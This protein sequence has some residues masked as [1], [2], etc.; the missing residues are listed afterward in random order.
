M[1]GDHLSYRRATGVAFLGLLLQVIVGLTLLIYGILGRDHAAFTGA[2]FVLVGG[3]IWLALGVVFDQHRRERIEA[4]EEESLAAAALRQSSVFD[5]ASGDLR[6]AARRLAWMHR[7]LMPAVSVLVASSF[8]ALGLL[9]F[10]SAKGSLNPD[11][12]VAPPQR[13]WAIAIGLCAAI[14]GFIFARFVSGMAKQPVWAN[15]RG[16]AAAAVGSALVG[17]VLAVAHFADLAG[18]PAMLRYVPAALCVFSVAMGAEVVLNL[19][20]NLYRPRKA[21]EVP[22]PAFDS[23]FLSFAAAPDKIAESVSGA[24]NYQFGFDV[25]SSWFYR[26]LSRSVLVLVLIG[27]GVVWLMT[28]VE[29]IEPNE[30]GLLL[31]SGRL[32]RQLEPGA[33]L[34]APWPI[35]WVDSANTTSVKRV[36]LATL[37]PG[38][39]GQPILWKTDHGVDEVYAIVQPSLSEA[40]GGTND[41]PGVRDLAL[42]AVEIPLLYVVSDLEKYDRLAP[43]EMRQSLLTAVARREALTYLA[44]LTEDD[45]LGRKR[46]EASREL[47]RRIAARFDTLDAGVRV[48]SVTLES[49]HPPRDAAAQ[50]ERVVLNEQRRQ[51]AVEGARREEVDTLT[52]AVGSLDLARTIAS[53]IDRLSEMGKDDAGAEKQKARIEELLARAGGRAAALI[54]TARADRWERHLGERGRAARYVGQL[55]AYRANPALYRAGLYFDAL[56]DA[57]RPLRVYIVGDDVRD[58]RM[59]LDLKDLD[60]GINV[61]QRAAE[62]SN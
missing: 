5:Q 20:L 62:A 54:E 23:R 53:E 12:F 57:M 58:L 33:Y 22:R 32:E 60:T 15:L 16:G 17:L 2:I 56:R 37:P 27:V 50:F 6:L 26:L 48:L 11:T 10:A 25:T 47:L 30:R 49:S 4:L 9:R 36:E 31:R 14:A 21:G 19:L 3:V 41:R 35:E 42:I 55:A 46:T 45:V 51:S 28:A 1:K 43:P 18:F 13:G 61:L 38:N 59:N 52:A 29:V 39:E 24:I 40:L 44:T 8:A 34:K 7:V